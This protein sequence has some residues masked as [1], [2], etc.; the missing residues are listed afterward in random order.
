[1]F[2]QLQITVRN[3]GT[4]ATREI[5]PLAGP[6]ALACSAGSQGE[7]ASSCPASAST[8]WEV[9]EPDFVWDSAWER[10]LL[11]AT[12]AAELAQIDISHCAPSTQAAEEQR[13]SV[14]TALVWLVLCGRV[15]QRASS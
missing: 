4:R 6:R 5:V 12:S 2:G 14:D 9:I 11:Q 8:R 1:M 13:S 3:T 7:T 10:A 15:C